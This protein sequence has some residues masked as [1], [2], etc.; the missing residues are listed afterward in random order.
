M[1]STPC[2]RITPLQSNNIEYFAKIR[3]IEDPTKCWTVLEKWQTG[4]GFKTLD[5]YVDELVP[6]V[7]SCNPN[8]GWGA[9]L[10]NLVDINYSFEIGITTA[11][12]AE[13]QDLWSNHRLLI[14]VNNW[15]IEDELINIKGPMKIELV[16]QPIGWPNWIGR[17]VFGGK[18]KT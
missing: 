1:T 15:T 9:N 3:N 10:Q 16:G 11:Q 6:V 5:D 14:G 12:Q 7:V 2:Y 8:T 13:L 18:Q 17:M 4:H